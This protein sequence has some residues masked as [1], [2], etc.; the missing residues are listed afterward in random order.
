MQILPN[1][2]DILKIQILKT[3][4]ADQSALFRKLSAPAES[5]SLTESEPNAGKPNH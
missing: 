3:I 1:P 2:L 4:A 5:H